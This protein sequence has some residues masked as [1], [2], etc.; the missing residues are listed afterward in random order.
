LSCHPQL[1]EQLDIRYVGFT[2]PRAPVVELLGDANQSCPVLILADKQ[3]RVRYDITESN[4]YPFISG[5][6]PIAKYL[7]QRYAVGFIHGDGVL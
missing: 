7:S 5:D 6:R 4:G 1:R 2:K 3:A